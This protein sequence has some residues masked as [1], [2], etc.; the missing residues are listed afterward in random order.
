M[1]QHGLID[2]GFIG[3]KFTWSHGGSV[4]TRRA[5]GLIEDYVTQNGDIASYG[6]NKT[7][8]PL[9]F[10]HC[11]MLLKLNQGWEGESDTYPSDFTQCG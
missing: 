11:P 4:N 7:L 5:G 6:I 9:L 3:Q 8:I 2:L 1:I 10:D